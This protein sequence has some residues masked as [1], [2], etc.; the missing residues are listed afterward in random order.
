VYGED[1]FG[2]DYRNQA[3]RRGLVRVGVGTDCALL[4]EAAGGAGLCGMISIRLGVR[5]LLATRPVDFRKGSHGLVALAAEVLGED[6][7][8]R[9]GDR[10]P[11]KARRRIKILIWDGS[12]LVL[13]WKQLTQNA[14]RCRT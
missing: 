4:T 10:V 6:P 1:R 2:A 7:V 14:F 11:F 12:S 3:G 13:I 8:L 5:V 9:H